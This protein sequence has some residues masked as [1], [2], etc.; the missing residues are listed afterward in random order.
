[1]DGVSGEDCE[2]VAMR[3]NDKLLDLTCD[4]SLEDLFGVRVEWC[5]VWHEGTC[6]VVL[7]LG[8][9]GRIF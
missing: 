4:R 8:V 2:V 1:M 7:V 3:R 6:S 5:L 9:F